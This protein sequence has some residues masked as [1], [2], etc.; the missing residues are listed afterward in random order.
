MEFDDHEDEKLLLSNHDPFYIQP[1]TQEGENG[2]EEKDSVGNS[3]EQSPGQDN[4][5]LSDKSQ[6][7]QS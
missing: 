3:Q 7:D 1:L 5:H 6:T 2:T 4:Y